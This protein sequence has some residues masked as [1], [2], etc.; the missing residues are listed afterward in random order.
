M[1]TEVAPERSSTTLTRQRIHR[2]T[3]GPAQFARWAALHALGKVTRSARAGK[4]PVSVPSNR[5]MKID[6][7]WQGD[8]IA[9][10]TNLWLSFVH[11]WPASQL[12]QVSFTQT[13][14]RTLIRVTAI[15]NAS[16]NI[17]VLYDE[18]ER[19]T[20]GFSQVED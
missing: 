8:E 5:H 1:A 14:A 11:Y 2:E 4:V 13:D 19:P 9:V 7:F 10:V 12:D 17:W 18:T 20:N 16:M 3:M 15:F 6:A